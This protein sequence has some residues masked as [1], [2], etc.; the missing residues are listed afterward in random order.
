MVPG[1]TS[2]QLCQFFKLLDSEVG[3][4]NVSVST[5]GISRVRKAAGLVEPTSLLAEL[6]KMEPSDPR[7]F[8]KL[9]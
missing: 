5:T 1:A 4:R 8:P 2:V 6:K 3:A 7:L 9:S